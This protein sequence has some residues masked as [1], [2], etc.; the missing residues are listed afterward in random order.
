MS[1]AYET[2]PIE[3]SVHGKL[4][5]RTTARRVDIS[6]DPLGEL[7]GGDVL[8]GKLWPFGTFALGKSIFTPKNYDSSN[9]D[10]DFTLDIHTLAGVKITVQ[11]AAITKMP[12]L[13]LSA[14]KTVMG[15]IT[16]T[17][18]GKDNTDWSAADSLFTIDSAAGDPDLSQMV[19]A[20]IRTVPYTATIASG[21]VGFASFRTIA[22]FTIDFDMS[23][24]PIETDTD[25]TVDM[26]FESLAV[27]VK[28]Q[29][30]GMTEANLV[31]AMKIQGAGSKRGSSL[32][33]N[34]GIDLVI[35]GA[36]SGDPKITITKVGLKSSGLDFGAASPRIGEVTFCATR[37]FVSG[38]AQALYTVSHV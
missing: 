5:E 4:D 1:L 18:I 14:T 32:Q 7:D 9:D 3:S 24:K 35:Q 30:L 31:S 25:G 34:L 23:T 37:S 12:S 21:P 33:G 20:N 15:G 8:S 17:A 22:G 38:V 11:S 26:V 16:F 28:C 2:M 10:A 6:F 19:L 36:A 13:M 29:P 27:N